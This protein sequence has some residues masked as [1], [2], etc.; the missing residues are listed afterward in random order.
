MKITTQKVIKGLRY[1]KHYGIKEFWIRLQEKMEAENVPYEPWYEKHK[2]TEE[3]LLQQR[4][5][6]A[7]WKDGPLVS[8][9]VPLYQTREVF[10]RELI[11]SVQAQTYAKWQ[12]CLADASPVES[13]DSTGQKFPLAETSHIVA[14]SE[15]SLDSTGRELKP[16]VFNSQDTARS[17]EAETAD[18]PEL[19]SQT[20]V[21]RVVWEYVRNDKRIVYTHLAENGGI[22]ENTNAAIALADGEWIGFADHDDLLAPDAL[23]EMVSL[24]RKGP[25]KEDQLAAACLHA[26]EEKLQY[27]M[28]YSDEDKVDMDGKTHFQPHLKPDFN[29]DLLRSN[30]YI[31]HFLLVRRA[32]LEQVGELRKEYDGAQDY[33]FIL[34]CAE[35]ARAIGH[36]PRI[37]YHWRCHKESTAENPF[38]KQYA[39]EA[40]KRAIEAHLAR[41][42][43]NGEVAARK[44]MGF[45]TVKYPVQGEP[46]VSVII[47]SRDEVE[48]LKKCLA[49]I[50][51]AD[52]P[53]YEVIIVENN[54]E[55]ETFAFYQT[56]A[57]KEQEENGIR[58]LEGTLARGQRICVAVWEEG[59]NY[60]RLNNFGASFARGKYLVLMNNDI[61]MMGT[62]WLAEMLG[63]CQRQEVG[64]VGTKLYYPDKTVQHAG[65]VVG[66][67]GNARGIGQNMFIGLPG[68]RGGYLHKASLTMDYSA[69]TAACLMVKH[70]IYDRVG[71]FTEELAVAFNDVDFCLKVRSLGYLVVYQPRAEG[72]HYESKSR[73]VEDSPEKVARFQREIE[74]MRTHWISILK[75]GDPYYNPNFSTT[76]PNYSLKDIL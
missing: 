29:L 72:Y 56:I 42:H 28:I 32:L 41:L 54:S 9:V 70:D 21:G 74:Y 36:V 67:G 59:F 4:K 7:G 13:L 69:V 24:I 19:Y 64:I 25:D 45:Y 39:V 47:P 18:G 66:I 34:R 58:R 37:L 52:Y 20:G 73:G 46:L 26:T 30:N 17:G 11:E 5:T 49:A 68:E 31:T 44:D 60:S 50:E 27:D 6:A 3:Q 10:L 62:T 48:S 61:E 12:L 1:L 33:D 8:I 53:N 14:T 75:N 40:G 22:A 35:C 51:R 55:A 65:V 57:P 2:A 63:T 16:E 23:F 15:E 76:Y 43:V 71:G 38:S